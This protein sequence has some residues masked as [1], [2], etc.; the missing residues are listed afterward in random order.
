MQEAAARLP[1]RT[2]TLRGTWLKD[3]AASDQQAMARA[4]DCMRLGGIQ[5][6]GSLAAAMCGPQLMLA[7]AARSC[8]L[9]SPTASLTACR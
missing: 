1:H 8:P 2:G 3:P 7:A 6:R 5:A 4:L 9:P